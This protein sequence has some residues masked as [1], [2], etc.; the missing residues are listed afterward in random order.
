MDSKRPVCAPAGSAQ[1]AVLPSLTPP[2]AAPNTLFV[3]SAGGFRF[4]RSGDYLASPI[5]HATRRICETR[6]RRHH[7]LLPPHP[8]MIARN[9]L[10]ALLSPFLCGVLAAPAIAQ[11]TPQWVYDTV[12]GGGGMIGATNAL[13]NLPNGDLLVGGTFVFA[14]GTSINRIARWNGTT[15]SALGAGTN[16]DVAALLSLPNGDLF[17]GGTFSNAGGVS[18]SRVARWDGSNWSPLG[19]GVNNRV[20]ALTT[21]PNGDLVAGGAFNTAGGVLAS[22]VARWDGANWSALGGGV[23]GTVATLLTLPNG[24]IIAGGYFTTAGGAPANR[25]ARWDGAIWSAMG[26]GMNSTVR[27]LATLPNGDIV[28]SGDFLTA[29]GVSAIRVARWD[30]L[31]WSPLGTG[32]NNAVSALT[33]LPSG[34]LIAAGF[35]TTAGGVNANRIARWNGNNWAP[36]GTGI[37]STS[38]FTVI[39][40]QNGNLVAGGSFSS[41][42]NVSSNNIAEYGCSTVTPTYIPAGAGCIGSLGVP[43]NIITSLPRLGE[44]MTADFTNLPLNLAAF[45]FGWNNTTS[46]FGTLPMDLGP[47]GAPGCL[48]RVSDSVVLLL[49]G[50]GN[51]ASFALSIPPDPFFLSMPFYTQALSIDLAANV[52][53]VVASDAAAAVIGN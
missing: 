23:G 13:A 2:T 12:A 49:A 7:T 33:V 50:S 21:L 29:G 46:S 1:L 43:G 42:N 11:C 18:T 32:M 51:V 44:T 39:A 6:R 38:V 48:L 5:G 20:N 40:R 26:T 27:A 52:L 15:W 45:V 34:E 4:T 37:G 35:F 8:T 28:A 19:N 24:D 36:L 22:R 53:G 14:G 30:G 17:A 25:I 41:A 31:N 10:L 47:V 16:G 3:C 9:S